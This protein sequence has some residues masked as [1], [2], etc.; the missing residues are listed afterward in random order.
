[1][2]WCALGTFSGGR[3]FAN[4]SDHGL[5]SLLSGE[6]GEGPSP[7][8]PVSSAWTISVGSVVVSSQALLGWVCCWGAR[9]LFGHGGF[10]G[11]A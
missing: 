2:G 11:A 6:V 7:V 4:A 9:V 10:P 1:M 3:G 8:L 5:V